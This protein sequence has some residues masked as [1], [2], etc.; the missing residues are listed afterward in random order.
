MISVG[1]CHISRKCLASLNNAYDLLYDI[2][3]T[4]QKMSAHA[5]QRCSCIS[6]VRSWLRKKIYALDLPDLKSN[7]TR[8]VIAMVCTLLC[9]TTLLEVRYDVQGV[10][11]NVIVI[12]HHPVIQRKGDRAIQLYCYFETGD[13]VVTNSYDVLSE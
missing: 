4:I 9:T 2:A 6:Q 8:H 3:N 11:S 5:I 13:K 12:Q 1:E 7:C 10:Y